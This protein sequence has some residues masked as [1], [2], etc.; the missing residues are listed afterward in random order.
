MRFYIAEVLKHT[1]SGVTGTSYTWT[2]E[3]A[4]SGLPEGTYNSAQVKIILESV[5]DGISSYNKYEMHVTRG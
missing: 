2:T 4:D 5:R 1:A 3:S